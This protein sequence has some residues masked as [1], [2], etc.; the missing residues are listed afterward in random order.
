MRER[1]PNQQFRGEGANRTNY[2]RG[3]EGSPQK[4]EKGIK[5]R[6]LESLKPN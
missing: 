1:T 4:I 3:G 5:R 6:K 2:T